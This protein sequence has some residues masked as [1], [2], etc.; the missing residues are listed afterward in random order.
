MAKKMKPTGVL[1]SDV[2]TAFLQ[3][4]DS[5]GD[6][7]T[8]R[9][10][11]A[12]EE[13]IPTDSIVWD[14]VLQLKG[15]PRGGRIIQIHGKEHGGKSTLTYSIIRAYQKHTGQPVCLFDFEG[16]CTGEYLKRNG[17]NINRDALVMYRE[18]SIESC[19]QKTVQ[20]L[21]AGVKVF[22]FDSV[23]RM[24]SK[25]DKKEIL[26][27]SAFKASYAS[28]A[29]SM[30]LFIDL[31]LPYAQ[32]N[33]AVFIMINQHRARID[34]SMEAQQAIKYGTITNTNYVLPGGYAMR[35]YPSLS[36]EVQVAKA[37]RAGGGESDWDIE[38]GEN[39][40]GK[41]VATKVRVRVMKNKVTMGGYREHHLYLRP[42]L[43]L[44]D[45][46]SVRELAYKYKLIQYKGRKYV[47]G[48]ESNPIATYDTKDEAIR[49]LVI[50][51][52][53]AV[54]AKLKE[55]VIS[56]IHSDTESFLADLS[57]EERAIVDEE[58][59]TRLTTGKP[60]AA[61]YDDEEFS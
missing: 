14:H 21:E 24:K 55:L 41:Y 10:L 37:I 38:P 3:V 54:L 2:Q 22:V 56:A 60:I 12:E 49:A 18:N 25:V 15:I 51:Q 31:L 61:P 23:P 36:I 48:L 34:A 6:D 28:H 29:K 17:V 4:I 58:A 11:D 47:V 53:P 33:D 27:G 30:N 19:I 26:N 52:D 44:D 45:N 50:D 39:K 40:G 9:N 43:G 57:L 1:S 46:I 7:P 59:Y 13:F 5:L 35:F 8:I 32:A 16:T 20:F 42:G